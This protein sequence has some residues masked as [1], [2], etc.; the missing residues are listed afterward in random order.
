[1]TKEE[2]A[3]QFTLKAMDSKLIPHTRIT[4]PD[5]DSSKIDTV[6]EFNADQ[7][8]GFYKRILSGLQ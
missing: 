4:S 1:M 2:L 6:V 7:I 8:S 5:V 3:M